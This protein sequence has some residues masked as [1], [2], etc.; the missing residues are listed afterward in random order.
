MFTAA[1]INFMALG[2][3]ES[4]WFVLLDFYT[5]LDAVLCC[6]STEFHA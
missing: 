3:C 4:P 6:Q 5:Q 2:Y 1:A